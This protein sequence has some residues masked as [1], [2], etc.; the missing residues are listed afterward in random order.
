MGFEKFVDIACRL[1]G[2]APSAVVLVA[3][4]QALKHHGGDPRRRARGDSS[5]EPRTWPRNL[6]IVR[7]FGARP[8]RRG[9]P[10]SGRQRRRARASRAGSRS[11]PARSPRRSTTATS[12]AA[13]AR[14]SSRKRSPKRPSG[15]EP[16]RLPLPARGPD[17]AKLEAIAT[18]ALRR[19]R[20]RALA[21]GRRTGRGAR[22]LGLGRPAGLHRQD[23]PLPL[24]RP[25]LLG[26]PH[27]FTLPVRELRA[28]TGAGWIVAVCGAMQTMPGLPA[29]PRRSQIDVDGDGRISGLR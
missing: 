14:S 17:P 28:Y 2:L 7:E 21:A 16:V 1:S 15:R 20:D 22:T 23:A 8:R 27:G 29:D 18:R 6:A 5:G 3:T 13:R 4:I 10:A 19:R 9:E 11:K 25:A 26:A 24:A 12:A